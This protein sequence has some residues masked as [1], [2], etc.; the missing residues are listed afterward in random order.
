MAI[1]KYSI[2]TNTE[3]GSISNPIYISDIKD[4]DN[5][6]GNFSAGC[7]ISFNCSCCGVYN[8]V[9]F[10]H[11]RKDSLRKMLCRS[12]K[13]S[14][15][16]TGDIDRRRAW[17]E[18]QIKKYGCLWSQ[19]DKGKEFFKNSADER[20]SKS[21]ATQRKN[22]NGLLYS[23]TEEFKRFMS[24]QNNLHPEWK[25]KA[26]KNKLINPTSNGFVYFGE[27]F[28]SI[29]ELSF[30]IYLRFFGI[31]VK[32]LHGEINY[33]FINPINNKIRHIYPDFMV[34]NSIVEIKG[35]M[36]FS[37]SGENMI[38]PYRYVK[39][40][41]LTDD[42]INLRNLEYGLK[43]NTMIKN[44]VVVIRDDSKYIINCKRFVEKIIFFGNKYWCNLFRVNTAENISYG[45][46]P[47]N[48]D[49]S[50]KYSL[51]TD[52]GLTPFNC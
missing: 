47:I 35:G 30:Y 36:Y 24:E 40:I 15:L 48:I 38:Y 11:C 43:Y 18:T 13:M 52:I 39:G 12:C 45:Y 6:N 21:I 33:S 25:E 27:S 22:N 29:A 10:K 14:Q 32:R 19:T 9:Q 4:F 50:N 31:N 23:Q 8:I 17:E 16:V 46:N 26:I 42:E 49:I 37:E 41:K 34:G 44:G 51:P 1:N 3:P 7:Y 5:M 2:Q 20:I 28:D